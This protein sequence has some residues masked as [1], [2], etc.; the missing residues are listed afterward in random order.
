MDT[1]ATPA[2]ENDDSSNDSTSNDTENVSVDN[3]DSIGDIISKITN[4]P[5]V[6]SKRQIAVYIDEDVAKAFDRYA[7][8][9]GKGAKSELIEEL[10]RP[11][12]VKLGYLK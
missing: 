4:K 9:V 11:T 6:N 2:I 5:K 3:T 7:R 1:V 8:R 12:L 10:L